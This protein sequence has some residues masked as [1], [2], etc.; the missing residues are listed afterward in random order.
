MIAQSGQSGHFFKRAG[1]TWMLTGMKYTST[2]VSPYQ[3]FQMV[4]FFRKGLNVKQAEVAMKKY[5]SHC[6][7]GPAVM[8][9]VEVLLN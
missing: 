8:M 1:S 4:F 2:Y 9:S 3:L 5:R 7:C 6:H